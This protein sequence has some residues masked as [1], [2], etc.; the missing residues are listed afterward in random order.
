M[1]YLEKYSLTDIIFTKIYLFKE[2]F[3]EKKKKNQLYYSKIILNLNFL[4]FFLLI[5]FIY[6]NYR[7]Y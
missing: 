4:Y 6:F 1:K 5:L 7:Y 3:N 2:I